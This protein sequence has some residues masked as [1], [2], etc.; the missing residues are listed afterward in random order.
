MPYRVKKTLR[1]KEKLLVTSNFS[2]SQNVFYS[3]ISL[4][5]QNAALC[6]NGLKVKIVWKS[7]NPLRHNATLEKEAFKS[8][9]GKEEN[10]KGSMWLE[11]M[12]SLN[13]GSGMG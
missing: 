8:I 5:H 13:K 6:G 10:A 12:E 4:V 7:I 3:Y 2:F 11:K 9:M 1:E